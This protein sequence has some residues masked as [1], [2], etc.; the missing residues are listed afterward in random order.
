MF[1]ALILAIATTTAP[2]ATAAPPAAAAQ[3]PVKPGG[4]VDICMRAAAA[5]SHSALADM[6]RDDCECADQQLHKLLHGGDY[7]I[8][9][10]MQTLLATGANEATFNKQLSDYMLQ[11]G[12]TQSDADAFFTRLKAAEAKTQGLC[13]ATPLLGPPIGTTP[14]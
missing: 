12:M 4:P 11:R 2:V 9:E 7:V 14:Q 1:L 8:H 3:A 10:E 6:D 5:V 13:S